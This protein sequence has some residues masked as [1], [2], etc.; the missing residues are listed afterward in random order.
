MQWAGDSCKFL[1]I[2]PV[3]HGKTE[4]G[5]D[6]CGVFGRLDL[7][8]G[9][10][11]RWIRQEVLLSYSMTQ[12]TDLLGGKSALFSAEFEFGVSQ[13][14]EDLAETGKVFFPG[15][16]KHDGV[17]EVKETRFPMKA[18]EDVIHEAGEGGGSVAEAKGG[19]IKLKELATASTERCL[20]FIPLHDRD[21]PVSTLEIKS[22]KP[23][24]PV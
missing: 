22:G 7:L 9:C 10:Q 3:I 4:E 17:I 15:G 1:N 2:S 5:A 20:F 21:L 8:D 19:L 12:V 18:R 23:A 6:F 13:S 14:L 24:S 11:E 16:G